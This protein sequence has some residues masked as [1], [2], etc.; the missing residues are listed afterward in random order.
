M[1][2]PVRDD[3]W[4]RSVNIARQDD[5]IAREIARAQSLIVT[6]RTVAKQ[7]RDIGMPDAAKLREDDA[8]WWE[9]RIEMWRGRD[10][11]TAEERIAKLKGKPM[12]F[13]NGR[14]LAAARKLAGITQRELATAAGVHFQTVK[15]WEGQTRPESGRAPQR[16]AAAL[17]KLGVVAKVTADGHPVL[18]GKADE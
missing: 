8:D 11:S 4:Q 1:N 16:F 2:S 13:A 14:H 18:E 5:R 10:L 12:F 9:R 3:R 17:A 6:L 15:Q 7:Y